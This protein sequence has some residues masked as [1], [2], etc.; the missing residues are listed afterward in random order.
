MRDV[1]ERIRVG[2]RAVDREAERRRDE[3]R[4]LKGHVLDEPA[5]VDVVDLDRGRGDR[6]D[7][8]RA[9]LVKLT[10]TLAGPAAAGDGNGWTNP[11]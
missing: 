5:R 2:H 3:R 4:G 1:R 6:D 8:L 10:Q 9:A 11:L 7:L